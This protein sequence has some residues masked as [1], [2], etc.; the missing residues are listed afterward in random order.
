MAIKFLLP[1]LSNTLGLGLACVSAC[2]TIR[3]EAN[4]VDVVDVVVKG[5]SMEAVKDKPA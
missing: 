5:C 1:R 3:R 2:R 4:V